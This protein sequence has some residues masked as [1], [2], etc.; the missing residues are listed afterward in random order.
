MQIRQL[1]AEEFE[2]RIALS[3]FAFQYKVA[4]ERLEEERAHFRPEETWGLFD[5][6]S[7]LL[8][9]LTILP[10]EIFVQG[11]ILRMGG[12]AGVASWPETRRGG[13]V[14]GLLKRS[15]EVMRDQGQTV[16]MLAPFQFSFYRKFGWEFTI[17]RKRYEIEMELLPKRK[18]APG[19]LERVSKDAGIFKELYRNF[20]SRYNGTLNRT[21]DWWSRKVL[22]RSG[23][24]VVWYDDQGQ[25]G[26]YICYEV[27]NRVLTVHDWAWND[28]RARAALWS[29]IANHD[30]M[31][32]RVHVTV[33]ESDDLSYFLPNPRFKQEI[34]PYFMSR[35]V[36]VEAFAALYPFR[37]AN[38]EERL[39]LEVRDEYAAWNERRFCFV[40]GTDGSC[41]LAAETSIMQGSSPIASCDIQVLTAMM[42]GNRRPLRLYESGLLQG[43]RQAA[44]ILERRIPLRDAYLADFF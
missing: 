36:D 43:D 32:E 15:L 18:D 40:L 20:A 14:T 31:A 16:S 24:A 38:D 37:E 1:T 28:N 7:K 21:E 27:Q 9:A 41:T 8:S 3:E 12:I 44:E 33:P 10:L 4:P 5:E 23:I 19:R 26:G 22:N 11:R 35:I 34:V 29:F 30:S 42:L 2:S 13:N 6:E 17:E 25:P 39:I